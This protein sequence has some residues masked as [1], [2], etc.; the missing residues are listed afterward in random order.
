MIEALIG[1]DLDTQLNSKEQRLCR[2][3]QQFLDPS[4]LQSDDQAVQNALIGNR[5][6]GL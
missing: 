2:L 3:W 4:A 1:V 5:R 6:P